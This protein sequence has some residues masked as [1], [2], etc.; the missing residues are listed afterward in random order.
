MHGA[1]A[2]KFNEPEKQHTFSTRDPDTEALDREKQLIETHPDRFVMF[3]ENAHAIARPLL[4]DI[5]DTIAHEELT[6]EKRIEFVDELHNV[7]EE[8]KRFQDIAK[9]TPRI[10]N[11]YPSLMKKNDAAIAV[12]GNALKWL[13]AKKS[14]STQF[15]ALVKSMDDVQRKQT[16]PPR[17]FTPVSDMPD[18]APTLKDAVGTEAEIEIESHGDVPVSNPFAKTPA[19]PEFELDESDFDTEVS[20]NTMRAEKSIG[21]VEFLIAHNSFTKGDEIKYRSTFQEIRDRFRVLLDADRDAPSTDPERQRLV[22]LCKATDREI[23]QSIDHI[24]RY[25][26]SKE[27]A[28]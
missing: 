17:S 18:A 4:E 13:K 12:V 14:P 16:E 2:F 28:A 11:A 1:E 19:E 10:H 23:Q 25:I 26:Q 24:E 27:K 15:T 22:A 6:P 9:R 7:Q 3:S 20:E 5:E 21:E 8:L